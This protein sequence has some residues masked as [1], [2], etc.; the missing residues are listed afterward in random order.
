MQ[1]RKLAFIGAGNMTR[2]IVAGL[3]ASGYP[4]RGY[5]CQ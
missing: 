4:K 2:S 1:H 3:V 5:Y